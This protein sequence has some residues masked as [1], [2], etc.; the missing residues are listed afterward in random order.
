MTTPRHYQR[1]LSC[2]QV[3]VI[4]LNW[5]NA[6]DTLACL[7]SVFQL[8]YPN[9]SVLVVD[10]GSTDDSVTRIREHYPHLTLL[11]TGENLG[12]AEGN[13]AGIRQALQDN[14]DYICMLNNDTI[15]LSNF[16]TELVK[17]M[18]TDPRIGMAG[19]K[20]YYFDP[21]NMLFSAGCDID[22]RRGI[23]THRGI[24][25]RD[26]HNKVANFNTAWDVDSI[27]GCG[28]LVRREVFDDVGLLDPTYFLNFEDVDWCV[29]TTSYGYRVRYVP[30]AVLYHKVSATLGQGSPSNTYYMTRNALQF[31]SRHG[32]HKIQAVSSILLRTLRTLGAWT[33]KPAYDSQM[34]KYR[35]NAIVLALHDSLMRRSGP[36]Q[37]T[38]LGFL[39]APSNKG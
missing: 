11:L 26:W 9:F 28:V 19:P 22:W 2:P 34:F 27:A 33:F 15:V 38:W 31:F 39:L 3:A 18:E 12:Y 1:G 20:M 24:Q 23:V 36:M 6:A 10:N 14:P 35:R 17:E 32:P 5:N 21:S 16:L 30:Q 7:E 29:R 37:A 25:Q 8:D 4:I 13:N